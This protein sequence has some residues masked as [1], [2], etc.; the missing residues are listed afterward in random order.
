M[1]EQYRMT[2]KEKAIALIKDIDDGRIANVVPILEAVSFDS[3]FAAYLAD[4]AS[5][6]LGEEEKE[7]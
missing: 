2:L 6:S 4:L 1:D 3:E 5:Q 7:N